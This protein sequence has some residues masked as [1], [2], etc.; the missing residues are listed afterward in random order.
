MSSV[1][2]TSSIYKEA[3]SRVSYSGTG[4]F[5]TRT[6]LSVSFFTFMSILA[7]FYLYKSSK[8]LNEIRED[9]I[10]SQ[11]E[12]HAALNTYEEIKYKVS[13]VS[14]TTSDFMSS[15]NAAAYT[16]NNRKGSDDGLQRNDSLKHS[17]VAP[18]PPS[19]NI[20]DVNSEKSDSISDVI[21]AND[22][23]NAIHVL[24]SSDSEIY[25]DAR[26][27]EI[28][29][30]YKEYVSMLESLIQRDVAL[31]VISKT[32]S[33][34]N[35]SNNE[36]EV[37]SNK[38]REVYSGYV[39]VTSSKNVEAGESARFIENMVSSHDGRAGNY[40]ISYDSLGRGYISSIH[41][42]SPKVSHL[43]STTIPTTLSS[44]L[45]TKPLVYSYK[46]A[47]NGNVTIFKDGKKVLD[48]K[49]PTPVIPAIEAAGNR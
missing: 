29:Y 20:Q 15:S 27:K 22:N 19:G 6:M 24:D 43:F 11:L 14:L 17:I 28:K 44:V 41:R 26:L 25:A 45:S 3:I 38:Y 33:A 10:A 30:K 18:V 31:A 49:T 21:L 13:K 40:L 47:R 35:L 36:I 7:G 5:F 2:N 12:L 46:F 4:K 32:P 37:M 16:D 34:K 8:L 48:Y 1:E 9:Q 23:G 39:F 42:E